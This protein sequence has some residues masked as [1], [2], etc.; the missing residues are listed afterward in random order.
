MTAQ[1]IFTTVWNHFVVN[2]AALSRPVDASR[3]GP[4][5]LYRGPGGSRCAVGCLITDDEYDVAMDS[6]DDTT[7]IGLN[8]R[9][10]LPDR[11]NPYV[12]M[13]SV[14]QGLHDAATDAED[15]RSELREFAASNDFG[16]HAP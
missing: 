8:D 3:Y 12:D 4:A 11:L 2:E 5:C 15:L 14:L 7:V 1:E 9:H 10:L 16:V 13:L 6:G